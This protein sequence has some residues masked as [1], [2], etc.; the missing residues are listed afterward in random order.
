MSWV[1]I[2]DEF[3]NHPKLALLGHLQ[4]PAIGLH[5]V[6]LC[7]CNS[8]LTDGFVPHGQID[9]LS[10]DLGLLLPDGK[11]D[12]IVFA[13]VDAGLWEATDGGWLIHDYLAYQPSRYEA[14]KAKQALSKER[15]KA[16]SRGAANKEAKRMQSGSKPASKAHAPYPIPIPSPNPISDQEKGVQEKERA[17]DQEA[18]RARVFDPVLTPFVADEEGLTGEWRREYEHSGKG[19]FHW[20]FEADELIKAYGEDRVRAAAKSTGW[21]KHPS[22]LRAKLDNPVPVAAPHANGNGLKGRYD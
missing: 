2:D 17:P 15:S 8:Y 22:Y 3:Y 12:S 19:L 21:I 1:R 5:V 6:A 9:K 18:P 11:P 13:L 14:L 20:A 4:L 16:G 7:W 10:G